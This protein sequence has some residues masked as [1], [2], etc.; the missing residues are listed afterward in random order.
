MAAGKRTHNYG[1][2]GKSYVKGVWC[3]G[4]IKQNSNGYTYVVGV[5]IFNSNNIYVAKCRRY[6][7][8]KYGGQESESTHVAMVTDGRNTLHMFTARERGLC[9]RVV[10]R[11]LVLFTDSEYI[12][13]RD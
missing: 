11:C 12:R 6:T 5:Y 2:G 13:I 9:S 4:H 3:L 1:N 8:S 7:G 10:R